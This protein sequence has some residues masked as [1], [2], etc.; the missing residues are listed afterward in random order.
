MAQMPWRR[1]AR[2]VRDPVIAVVSRYCSSGMHAAC[3]SCAAAHRDRARARGCH[4]VKMSSSS[5][6]SEGVRARSCSR[7]SSSSRRRTTFHT[8]RDGAHPDAGGADARVP[9]RAERRLELFRGGHDLGEP[10][11]GP[12]RRRQPSVSELSADRRRVDPADER[13][14]NITRAGSSSSCTTSEIGAAGRGITLGAPLGKPGSRRHDRR[15]RASWPRARAGRRRSPSTDR[16]RM[17]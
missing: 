8:C 13:R 1:E 3:A 14:R 17:R 4:D 9:F 5:W 10:N 7:T 2:K 16:G 6:R 15:R 11:P 12:I